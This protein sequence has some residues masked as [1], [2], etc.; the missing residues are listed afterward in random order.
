MLK[1]DNKEK[2][3]DAST[4]SSDACLA[5]IGFMFDAEQETKSKVLRF[6]PNTS[7]D[8]EISQQILP[9]YENDGF[10]TEAVTV[11]VD[12]VDDDPGAVQ[13]GHYLWPGAPALAQFLVDIFSSTQK[14]S[15]SEQLHE[16]LF[17]HFFQS[18]QTETE[19]SK[20]NIIELGAGCGLAGLTTLQ[21]PTFRNRIASLV[22]TDHDPGTLKRAEGNYHNTL[23][24]KHDQ[25]NDLDQS[26]LDL[27]QI[28]FE[29]LT[30]GD[31]DNLKNLYKEMKERNEFEISS[32]DI[33]LGSDLI[34]C[35]EVVKPLLE[36]ISWLLKGSGSN[37]SSKSVMI[38]TQSF[39]YDIETENAIDNACHEL[40]LNRFIVSCDL[41]SGGTRIQVFS[42]K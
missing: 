12:C 21:L 20:L 26:E 23:R 31:K 4:S 16:D 27:V 25:S 42:E 9:A 37:D 8:D 18:S 28:F 6:L 3:D 11:M 14:S 35:E 36:S 1:E 17:S 5:E 38:M 40:S 41:T 24:L 30:W 22:F 15:L 39:S 33:V 32:F 10:M 34:Y 7:K 2:C 19:R 13:S 29:E